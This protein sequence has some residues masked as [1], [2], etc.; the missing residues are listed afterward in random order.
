MCSSEIYIVVE[1]SVPVV[2]SSKQI[3]KQANIHLPH[4][5]SIYSQEVS[6]S[7][8]YAI[9]TMFASKLQCRLHVPL[10][11]SSALGIS[12]SKQHYYTVGWTITS[13]VKR[14]CTFMN[15]LQVDTVSHLVLQVYLGSTGEKQLHHNN[16]TSVTGQHEG[17]LAI[18]RRQDEKILSQ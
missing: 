10:S 14:T 12:S 2:S 5:F 17:S 13:Q 15:Q 8:L 18:L 1:W 11:L 16:V 7:V 9:K 3:S 4:E 6:E